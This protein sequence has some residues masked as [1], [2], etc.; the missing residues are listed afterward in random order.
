MTTWNALTRLPEIITILMRHGFTGYLKDLGLSEKIPFHKR[1]TTEEKKEHVKG[2][3]LRAAF[4]ELGP[5]FMKLGQFISTRTDILSSE[6]TVPLSKLQSNAPPIPFDDIK[7]II[8]FESGG[9]LESSFIE[10]DETPIGTASLGQVH[11]AVLYSGEQVAVKVRRPHIEMVVNQDIQVLRHLAAIAEKNSS[12]ARQFSLRE[13][14][15]EFASS[16]LKEMNYRLEAAEA[17]SVKAQIDN[18]WIYVPAIFPDYTSERVLVM[19]LVEG[20]KL[21]SE[22]IHQLSSQRRK[23][24][25]EAL[26][27]SVLAQVYVKGVFHADP[28]PGNLILLKNETLALIDFGNTGRLSEEMKQLLAE[29][30]FSLNDRDSVSLSLAIQ[31]LGANREVDTKAMRRDLDTW[32]NTYLDRALQ[33]VKMGT[34][35]QELFALAAKHGIRVPRE[36][37]QVGQAFLKVEQTVSALDPDIRF[38]VILKDTGERLM[39]EQLHPKR[40]LR[41]TRK[42]TRQVQLSARKLPTVLNETIRKWENGEPHLQMNI[43]PDDDMMSRIE[44]IAHMLILSIMM[45]A[46][47]IIIAGVIIGIKISG[48]NSQLTNVYTFQ[49]VLSIA[50]LITILFLITIYMMWRKK[51]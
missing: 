30:L 38:N 14:I 31:S 49:I 48:D 50:F 42:L 47:S 13:T 41:E 5:T 40:L 51:K 21:T 7:Q 20:K 33:E 9:P 45:L 43:K 8:E 10:F 39:W 24:L 17:L 12:L 25:A 16:L 2:E 29:C 32:M 15:D 36:F 46:F 44:R 35:F 6:W 37:I 26:A 19:E 34:M 28:H 1:G 27:E 3:E 4:E 18:E 23:E 11:R 22:T